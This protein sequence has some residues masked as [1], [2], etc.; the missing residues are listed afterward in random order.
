[1]PTIFVVK[2]FMLQMDPVIIKTKDPMNPNNE[3]EQALPSEM[4]RFAVGVHEVDD[5][6]ANHWYVKA[7]LKGYVPPEKGPGFAE[8][9]PPAM[10]TPPRADDGR[11]DPSQPMPADALPPREAPLPPGVVMHEPLS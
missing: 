9:R 1:M 11:M 6:I 4:H 3:I 8:Y 2:P 10:L 7:H 5:A